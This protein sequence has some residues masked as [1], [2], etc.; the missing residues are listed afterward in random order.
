M[1]YHK[2]LVAKYNDLLD[3]YSATF[4]SVT[5]ELEQLKDRYSILMSKDQ[6]T[7]HYTKEEV[8][9][10]KDLQKITSAYTD[11][12][13]RMY[14]ENG[15]DYMPSP[16]IT[17]GAPEEFKLLRWGLIPFFMSDRAKAFA[18]RPSTLNCISEEMYEKRSFQDAAKNGQR[19]LIPVT[20]FYEW[21]WVDE[22]GKVKIP[23]FV[24]FKEQPIISVAGLYSRW[25][26]RS[27]DEYYYSYTVLTTQANG[28]ME[29]VHNNKKRMPVIIPK[30]YEKDWLNKDLSKDDVL[31]LCQPFKKEAMKA[32]TISK[33]ITTREA[34]TNV[35]EVLK[36]H[37]YEK[38]GTDEIV[39]EL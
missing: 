20:G 6:K 26:D 2:S 5:S 28:L 31:A 32:N 37:N 13:Y 14:H 7:D 10:L 23:Y 15:F 18:L 34:D 35:D 38:V 27:N 33:L 21:R 39:S 25:K 12:E 11:T 29:Y 8:K 4:D 30:E 22:K 17:A 24:S 36:L 19:C 16:I 1:C 9:E 3:H